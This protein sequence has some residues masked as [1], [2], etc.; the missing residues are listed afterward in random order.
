MSELKYVYHC[1]TTSSEDRITGGQVYTNKVLQHLSARGVNVKEIHPANPQR[2]LWSFLRANVAFIRQLAQVSDRSSVILQDFY[3]HPWFFIAGLWNRLFGTH[4]H[5]VFV[6]LFYH[7]TQPTGLLNFLD[8]IVT[9]ISLYC[10]DVIIANSEATAV[11]CQRLAGRTVPVHVIYPGCDLPNNLST[12]ETSTHNHGDEIQLLSISNYE[13]RKGIHEL[14]DMMIV[15]RRLSATSSTCIKLIVAGKPDIDPDY[16]RGLK[17]FIEE[18]D[19]GSDIRLVGYKDRAQ[20]LELFASSDLFV[21]A[22]KE[23]GFGMVIAEATKAGLPIVA[24]DLPPLRQMVH[25]GENGFLVPQGDVQAMAQKVAMIVV[26]PELRRIMG[27][28]SKEISK[29]A[30]PSWDEVCEQFYRV[31]KE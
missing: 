10:A 7:R 23:E 8:N 26:D 2:S 12:A 3:C 11:E 17:A 18:Q 21:F 4:H 31:L 28:A 15:L 27:E 30:A 22:S 14:L 9:R 24:M 5:V 16:T 6:Q 13:R 25:D 20:V 19:T 1:S 29:H